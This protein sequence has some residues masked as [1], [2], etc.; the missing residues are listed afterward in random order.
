M[1]AK[2]WFVE[3]DDEEELEVEVDGTRLEL[4]WPYEAGLD[5]R[6]KAVVIPEVTT[7]EG[8]TS[9]GMEIVVKQRLEIW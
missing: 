3:H 5:V 6:L 4:A 1:R 8:Y 2:A 7:C 9:C